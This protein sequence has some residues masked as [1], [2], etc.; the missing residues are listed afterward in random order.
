ML[1]GNPGDSQEPIGCCPYLRVDLA[2]NEMEVPNGRRG[3][4]SRSKRRPRPLL[5]APAAVRAECLDR[6]GDRR[7]CAQDAR[8]WILKACRLGFHGR[9]VESLLCGGVFLG[10]GLGRSL[11]LEAGV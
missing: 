9:L 11:R 3:G 6:P 10:D 7:H 8:R 2:F 5:G 4:S 1:C